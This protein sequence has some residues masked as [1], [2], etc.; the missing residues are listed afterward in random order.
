MTHRDIGIYRLTYARAEEELARVKKDKRWICNNTS[1]RKHYCDRQVGEYCYSVRLHDTDILVLYADGGIEVGGGAWFSHPTTRNRLNR[2][3]AEPYRIDWGPMSNDGRP[4]L[5]CIAVEGSVRRLPLGDR[6]VFLPNG[7]APAIELMN[8]RD[9][10]KVWRSAEAYAKK[11]AQAFMYGR[12]A[13]PQR[14]HYSDRTS[15]AERQQTALRLLDT[16]EVDPAPLYWQL[17]QADSRFFKEN[18]EYHSPRRPNA[19]A[20]TVAQW[21]DDMLLNKRNVRPLPGT[22]EHKTIRKCVQKLVLRYFRE[23]LNYD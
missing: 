21:F 13:E 1:L 8:N 23:A 14:P 12:V 17:R 5:M 16:Q 2:Y 18:Y 22:E 20:A 6:R 15:D 11:F 10:L 19:D 7:T 3:L 4:N 9:A